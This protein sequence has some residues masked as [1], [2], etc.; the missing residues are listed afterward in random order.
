MSELR[1]FL[2]GTIVAKEHAC[3][4]IGEMKRRRRAMR[5]PLFSPNVAGRP[6]FVFQRK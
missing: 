1:Y 4:C 3:V 5:L 2:H 6:V